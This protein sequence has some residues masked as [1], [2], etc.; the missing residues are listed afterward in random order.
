MTFSTTKCRYCGVEF[1]YPREFG[2]VKYCSGR[3]RVSHVSPSTP[4]EFKGCS[5]A[6]YY[7]KG[8][9]RKISQG[10]KID[11]LVI[12]EYYDWECH[13]CN[14]EIDPDLT[15]PDPGCA[16]IDHRIELSAGG[17]HTWDNVFPAHLSC[18]QEKNREN[19]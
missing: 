16:S 3:C 4:A 10:D 1:R 15:F 14:E 2:R 7:S 5:G 11:Y 13:L 17:T 19:M 18:N 12:Y 8:R 6:K 9:R